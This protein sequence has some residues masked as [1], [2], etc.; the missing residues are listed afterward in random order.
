M[1]G[2]GHIGESECSKPLF[3]VFLADLHGAILAEQ[4]SV[5]LDIAGRRLYQDSLVFVCGLS[6]PAGSFRIPPSSPHGPSLGGW[7]SQTAWLLWPPRAPR[8]RDDETGG[9]GS[10]EIQRNPTYKDTRATR[11]P[12]VYNMGAKEDGHG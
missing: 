9:E 10:G 12:R 5:C 11:L 4:D 2:Q 7:E 8:S 1:N 6:L 3:Y